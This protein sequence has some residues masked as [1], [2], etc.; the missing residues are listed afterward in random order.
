MAKTPT[1]VEKKLNQGICLC[2]ISYSQYKKAKD[3]V[4]KSHDN[5]NAVVKK[6]VYK[7]VNS[8]FEAIHF[9]YLD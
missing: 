9:H 6:K 7:P 4:H 5:L 3:K 2:E 8:H 1:K